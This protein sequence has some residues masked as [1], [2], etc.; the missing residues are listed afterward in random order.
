MAANCQK[1]TVFAGLESD[2]DH[3]DQVSVVGDEN[4][5]FDDEDVE[6]Q[7]V[8]GFSS[9]AEISSIGMLVFSLTFHSPHSS[10][11]LFFQSK[12]AG[13]DKLEMDIS[14][15]EE[16]RASALDSASNGKAISGLY[17]VTLTTFE[18][19]ISSF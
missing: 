4:M 17:K 9:R 3:F 11:I 6:Q 14:S 1:D 2:I 13:C 7:E 5:R 8:S 19:I 16:M 15:E 12:A 10:Y 18:V